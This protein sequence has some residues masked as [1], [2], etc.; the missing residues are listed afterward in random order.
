MPDGK[1]D[2]VGYLSRTTKDLERLLLDMESDLDPILTSLELGDDPKAEWGTGLAQRARQAVECKQRAWMK[3][4]DLVQRLAEMV[5]RL[6]S[7]DSTAR[8]ADG[9]RRVANQ[10]GGGN[11]YVNVMIRGTVVEE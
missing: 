6:D 10:S 1:G 4:A 7:T 5:D 2:D 9:L 11:R 8:R 3:I